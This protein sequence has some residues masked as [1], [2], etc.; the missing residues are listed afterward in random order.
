MAEQNRTVLKSYF[1][2]GD[3]PSQQQFSDLI[4]SFICKSD[5]ELSI[6]DARNIGI[7][8][9]S[10]RAKLDVAG[11]LMAN[12]TGTGSHSGHKLIQGTVEGGSDPALEVASTWNIGSNTMQGPAYKYQRPGIEWCLCTVQHK[13]K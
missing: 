4:D 5:D 3:K 1:Q 10:P 2:T 11:T 12:A 9:T 6:N 8:T 7:G 13:K